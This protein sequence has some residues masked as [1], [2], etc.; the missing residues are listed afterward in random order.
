MRTSLKVETQGF[1]DAEKALAALP[2]STARSVVRRVLKKTLE[3]MRDTADSYS[4]QFNI[5][6]SSKLS[7]RQRGLARADFAG[8]VV[9]MYVGP[10]QEDGSHAPHA[11]LIEF[12]TAERFH[13]DG[14]AVG[15]INPPE[16]FMR[17]AYDLWSATALELLGGYLWAE[18]EKT[19]ARR[20]AKAARVAGK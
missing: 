3:P 11:H 16:P 20:A 10:V 1:R 6:I 17:P 2:R 9:A 4:E 8:H 7:P 12:G 19:V 15:R 14:K 5:A 18:I 13:K